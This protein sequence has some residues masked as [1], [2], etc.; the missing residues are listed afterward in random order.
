MET[1]TRPEDAVAAWVA[2][3]ER[4]WRE[5]DGLDRLFTDDMRYWRSPYEEP[6]DLAAVRAWWS[7]PAPFTWTW[8][9]VAVQWPTAVVRAEVHY[10]DDPP[11]EYRDL[12][13]LHFADDGRVDRFE[14][15]PFSP[16]Q[17]YTQDPD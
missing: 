4:V 5:D 16:G 3:Y 12:W 6:L 14:E 7:D 9:L 8:E 2:D 10:T 11:R 1:N 17:P 13:V 15:W